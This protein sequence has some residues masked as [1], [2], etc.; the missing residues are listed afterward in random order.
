[1]ARILVIEDNAANF[2]LV[3]YLLKAAGHTLQACRDGKA[4]LEALRRSPPELVLCDVQLPGLSGYE[5]AAAV[6]SEPALR[7]IPMVA[8][9]ALAM[10]GDAE[11]A[12]AAG[13]AGYIAKPIEPRTFVSD[14][15]AYLPPAA[16]PA[17]G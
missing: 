4:G 17:T 10:P 11:K 1:M 9:T 8:V 12:R 7:A 2:A 5:I 6:R 15:A 16:R 3:S 13:F 14:V